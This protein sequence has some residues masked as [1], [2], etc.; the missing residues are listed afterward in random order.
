MRESAGVADCVGA[1]NV[2]LNIGWLPGLLTLLGDMA[3]GYLAAALGKM[4]SIRIMP[5]LMPAFAIAGH[6]WSLWLRFRGG[7]GLATFIGGCL[8]VTD[9][10]M[11]LCGLA[12]WGLLY[13][14]VR[15]HDRSA[16]MACVLLPC[17][18]LI[19]GQSVETLTFVSTSSLT[20]LLRRLQSIK[21]RARQWHLYK[22]RDGK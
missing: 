13:L 7:G 18:T 16:V 3:K 8:A 20:V 21:E 2:A 22:Q 17:A 19:A 9:W 6:N 12:L 14:L 1:T 15:D 4:S 11:A 5:F 10:R